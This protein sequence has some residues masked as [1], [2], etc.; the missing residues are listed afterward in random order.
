M[1][2]KI[3]VKRGLFFSHIPYLRMNNVDGQSRVWTQIL[4]KNYRGKCI[5]W[6]FQTSTGSVT[7]VFTG[8]YYLEIKFKKILSFFSLKDAI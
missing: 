6:C 7:D 5:C 8:I 2:E 4:Q 1:L 3:F